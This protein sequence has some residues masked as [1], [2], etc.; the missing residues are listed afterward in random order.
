MKPSR[1][2]AKL[3]DGDLFSSASSACSR[4][5]PRRDMSLTIIFASW[6][7]TSAV[8]SS[9]S[10]WNML[11]GVMPADARTAMCPTVN[12]SCESSF[13]LREPATNCG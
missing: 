9:A 4:S 8:S 2:S 11:S 10:E 1:K 12:E 6:F 13:L 7:T 3:S 5:I